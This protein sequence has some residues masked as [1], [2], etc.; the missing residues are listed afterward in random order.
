MTDE[1]CQNYANALFGLLDSQKRVAALEALQAVGEDL[2][3]PSDFA[4]LLSSYNLSLAE[5]RDVLDHV[6]GKALEPIPQLL[7]FLKVVSD[8]HRL[9]KLDKIIEAYASLVHEQLGIKEGVVYSAVKLTPSE[10]QDIE[11]AIAKRLNHKVH[12]KNIVDHRLLGG[13]K[14]AIDGKVFDG[15]LAHKLEDLHRALHGGTPA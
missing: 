15:S 7:S 1:L 14:V 11:A 12:L 8:H 13:A 3:G 10:L 4:R 9:N 5:K 2:R 6:Y